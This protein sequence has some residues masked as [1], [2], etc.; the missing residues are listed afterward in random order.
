MAKSTRT[1]LLVAA[2]SALAVSGL[3]ALPPVGGFL[4]GRPL[5]GA[6]VFPGL[7]QGPVVM[8]A[9]TLVGFTVTLTVGAYVVFRWSGFG[10]S[11]VGLVVCWGL[12]GGPAG[13]VAVLAW[14]QAWGAAFFEY[15]PHAA[16]WGMATALVAVL[17]ALAVT[18]TL[19]AAPP[20][21]GKRSFR[22]RRWVLPCLVIGWAV[23]WSVLLREREPLLAW[24]P[25]SFGYFHQVA[26]VLAA[27]VA[28]HL[29]G[30]LRRRLP[31]EGRPGRTFVLAWIALCSAPVVYAAV[32]AIDRGMRE[33]LLA[34]PLS[35][36]WAAEYVRDLGAALVAEP[37]QIAL[38]PLL[39]AL[40]GTG[41]QL[42]LPAKERPPAA[43]DPVRSDRRWSLL[44]AGAALALTYFCVAATS[45][46]PV[47]TRRTYDEQTPMMLRA[48]AFL[49]PPDP[50]LERTAV[51]W[52]WAVTA[53]FGVLSAVLVYVTVRGQLVRLFP[54][55]DY[56]LLVGAL[57]LA[58]ALAWNAG[59][60]I[61]RAVTGERLLGISPARE[62]AVFTAVV[63]PAFAAL[64]F[65]VH[66]QVG[67]SRFVR[68]V[69]L[70][71]EESWAKL[72]ERYRAW[73]EQVRPHLPS[74]RERGVIAARV[75]GGALVTAVVAGALHGFGVDQVRDG[76][77]LLAVPALS[78]RQTPMEN[79][80]GGLYVVLLAGLV[81]LGFGRLNG[82]ERR[83]S[84]WPAVWGLSVV[85]GGLAALVREP[86]DPMAGLQMG[87]VAGPFAAAGLAVPIR[88]KPLLYAAV[89][90]V[91]VTAAPAVRQ[92]PPAPQQ[93]VIGSAAWRE[94]RPRLTID[95]S[96][97]RAAGEDVQRLNAAL[98]APVRERVEDALRGLRA[99]PVATG[100]VTGTHL[101][102]RNDAQVISVRYLMAGEHRRALNYDVAAG[103]S[104]TVYDIFAPAALTPA[105]RRRL[106][107]ALRPFM[108]AGQDPRTVTVDNDRLLVNL[109]TG[110]VEFAFGRGY[111]CTGCAPFTV[112]VPHER[113]AGLLRRPV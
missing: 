92:P 65:I 77:G 107:E 64:L 85:A 75:A 17:V 100:A 87:F 90:L 6:L 73:K 44:V 48:L 96:Y 76:E 46:Y 93:V 38:P 70:E 55:S 33:L 105:G 52:L 56:L 103:R 34:D 78:V 25:L 63:V 11:P 5:V 72:G 88:R 16:S 36:T 3:C 71:G 15:G 66:S 53:A 74:R 108:P 35:A 8:A 110:A 94:Q 67:L 42:V 59:G 51:V 9:A 47:L 21:P 81:Y 22:P 39:L 41:L 37:A 27:V 18:R 109:G 82:Q 2:G 28:S 45:R 7:G 14:A 4:L 19:P 1:F 54:A 101:V 113:L 91:V 57:A 112:R 68:I 23:L 79:L 31:V 58:A 80:A 49:A 50:E 30:A 12:A 104:L 84:S 60:V 89:L 43:P 95:V 29:E 69:E 98:F 32:V 99:N 102:V 106:A 97:P 86:F 61:A 13:V 40:A 20:E 24:L 83:L 26:V 10:A 62:A 111:F